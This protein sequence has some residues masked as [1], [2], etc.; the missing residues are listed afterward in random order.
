MGLCLSFLRACAV[1]TMAHACHGLQFLRTCAVRTV[2]DACHCLQFLRTCAVPTMTYACH[3]LQFLH[4]CAVRT[5]AHACHCLQFL[6]TCAVRTVAH[7]CDFL[8]W[9]RQQKTRRTA[10]SESVT[11]IF[12]YDVV[13]A[14]GHRLSPLYFILNGFSLLDSLPGENVLSSSHNSLSFGGKVTFRVAVTTCNSIQW[15]EEWGDNGIWYFFF[16]FHGIRELPELRLV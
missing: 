14:K 15:I 2:A 11:L 1:R 4:T 6:R 9:G 13:T 8:H 12:C 3:C 7:S 10:R 16:S 5:V